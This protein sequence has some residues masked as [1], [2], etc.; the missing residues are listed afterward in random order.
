MC[1]TPAFLDVSTHRAPLVVDDALQAL[2]R[3]LAELQEQL[4]QARDAHLTAELQ[5]QANAW[6][7]ELRVLED[8]FRQAA[9]VGQPPGFGQTERLTPRQRDVAIC[10]AEGLSNESTAQ[11]LGITS[12]TT[13]NHIEHILDRLRLRTRTQIAV[14]AAARGLYRSGQE[15]TV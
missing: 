15:P 9:Q 5:A 11:R 7:R 6:P 1:G 14:W 4:N 10:I 2:A 8:G 3:G 12:G 13:A